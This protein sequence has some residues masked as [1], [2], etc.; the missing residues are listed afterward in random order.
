MEKGLETDLIKRALKNTKTKGPCT[1]N[2]PLA[3]EVNKAFENLE[4]MPKQDRQASGPEMVNHP[5]HYN[6]YDEE[7]IDM[8]ED[9][10]GPEATATFCK[11]NAFKYRMRM[12][13]KGGQE[14]LI[15][16]FNKEQ[17]YLDKYN[18]LIKTKN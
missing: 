17:W 4:A 2:S 15:E 16:D 13:T 7:V 3:V 1:S 10:W 8:M 9:I 12:G 14:K 11:L 18:Q 6:N 5:H